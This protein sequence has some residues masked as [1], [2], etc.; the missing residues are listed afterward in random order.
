MEKIVFA[1]ITVDSIKHVKRE[2][3]NQFLSVKVLF[4]IGCGKF[5]LV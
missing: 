5:D 2:A 3:D 1:A 4:S